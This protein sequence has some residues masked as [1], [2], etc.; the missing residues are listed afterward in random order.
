MSERASIEAEKFTV[1]EL[2][3]HREFDSE[4]DR[5]TFLPLL[6]LVFRKET[7]RERR[8]RLRQVPPIDTM[9]CFTSILCLVGYMSFVDVN[10]IKAS[11][12][13]QSMNIGDVV[14][15]IKVIVSI[16][17]GSA[18]VIAEDIMGNYLEN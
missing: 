10:R 2:P 1:V 7:I 13:Y 3:D 12:D 14:I 15:L 8:R 5:L 9:Y 18:K 11:P 4:A 16:S 6:S 17:I